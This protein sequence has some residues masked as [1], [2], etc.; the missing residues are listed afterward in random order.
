M[1]FRSSSSGQP[2]VSVLRGK[3]DGEPKKKG[4]RRREDPGHSVS[5]LWKSAASPA[6]TLSRHVDHV[7]CRSSTRSDPSVETWVT[8]AG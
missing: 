1:H 4:K 7:A 6:T 8:K 5:G 3:Q 2:W